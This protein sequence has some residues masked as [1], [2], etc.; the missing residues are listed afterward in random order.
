[1]A[2]K[3]GGSA[4]EEE[5]QEEDEDEQVLVKTLRNARICYKHRTFT[6]YVLPS[7]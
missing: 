7:Q 4:R 5:K 2:P 3:T 1:M 6:G